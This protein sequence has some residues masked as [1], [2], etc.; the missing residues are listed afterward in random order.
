MTLA[1]VEAEKSIRIAAENKNTMNK[2]ETLTLKAVVLYILKNCPIRVN[3][4]VYYIVKIAFVAQQKHLAKY[5]CPLYEDKIVAL[6]FGPVPSNIYDALKIARGDSNTMY[7]HRNDDLHLIFDSISFCDEVYTANEE[8]DMDYLSPSAVECINEAISEISKMDF[9]QIV[10]ATHGEEWTRAYNSLCGK[11]MS[12]LA[13]A[14]EGGAD[15]SSISYLK[16][17]LELD[18]LLK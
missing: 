18:S 14:K 6:Q 11:N 12:Y 10:N 1:L 7:F 9:V 3:R 13:I 16:E 2:E 17:N 4:N 8:P 5:L 15:E